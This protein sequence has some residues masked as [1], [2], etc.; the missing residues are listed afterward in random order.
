MVGSN[1]NNLV[2]SNEES[3]NLVNAST[4]NEFNTSIYTNFDEEGTKSNLLTTEPGILGNKSF[5]GNEFYGYI[6]I[7]FKCKTNTAKF[8][9][10]PRYNEWNPKGCS[11]RTDKNSCSR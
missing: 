9:S 4:I 3:P 6:I 10:D 2:Y 1:G 11:I 8:C 5:R 7:E